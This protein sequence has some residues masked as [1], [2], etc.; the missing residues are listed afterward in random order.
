MSVLNQN[1][2][3]MLDAI[4]QK[5]QGT[6][7]ISKFLDIAPVHVIAH[8]KKLESL[9][10]LVIGTIGLKRGYQRKYSLTKKGKKINKLNLKINQEVFG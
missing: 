8:R 10:L 1:D 6:G 5:V 3:K 9:G 4:D 7:N 2:F